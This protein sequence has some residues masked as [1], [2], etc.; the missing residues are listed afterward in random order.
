M[1]SPAY[2]Y[3]FPLAPP[4]PHLPTDFPLTLPQ[5]HLPTALLDRGRIEEV[6]GRALAG[7][8]TPGTSRHFEAPRVPGR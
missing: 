7:G 3:D 4:Q 8:L 1:A 5:P 2:D 6:P